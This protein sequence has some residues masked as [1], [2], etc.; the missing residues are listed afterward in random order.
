[1]RAREPMRRILLYSCLVVLWTLWE[2]GEAPAE[3][4]NAMRA[5]TTPQRTARLTTSTPEG[6]LPAQ[7]F[8]AYL[9]F[10]QQVISPVDGTRS[11]MYPTGSAYARQVIKKHGAVLGVVLTTERLM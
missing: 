10:F 1:M 11:N 6:T 4:G 5:P 7:V 3:Q 8:D 9:R 2:V